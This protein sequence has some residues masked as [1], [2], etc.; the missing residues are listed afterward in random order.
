ML[1]QNCRSR[2]PRAEPAS[3]SWGSERSAAATAIPRKRGC[4]EDMASRHMIE[5]KYPALAGMNQYGVYRHCSGYRR[6]CISRDEVSASAGWRT[7]HQSGGMGDQAARFV[8]QALPR[9]RHLPRV[10][11]VVRESATASVGRTPQGVAGVPHVV[12]RPLTGPGRRLPT[13]TPAWYN[14]DA[15]RHCLSCSLSLDNDGNDSHDDIRDLE[16]P[17]ARAAGREEPP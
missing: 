10:G 7:G 6:S 14:A 9:S 16:K 1:P 12:S 4:P 8:L 3:I 17:P 15:V 5:R 2:L 11:G 13:I